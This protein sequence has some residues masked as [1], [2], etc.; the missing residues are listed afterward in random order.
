MLPIAIVLTLA[1]SSS[2]RG[3]GGA[4]G[5]GFYASRK[6]DKFVSGARERIVERDVVARLSAELNEQVSYTLRI[7]IRLYLLL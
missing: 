7:S 6:R 5:S 2:L 4:R 1:L 3:A